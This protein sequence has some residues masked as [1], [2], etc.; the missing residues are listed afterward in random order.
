MT[1]IRIWESENTSREERILTVSEIL[2]F[3][4]IVFCELREERKYHEPKKITGTVE[5]MTIGL[6]E[7]P[8]DMTIKASC[9]G[10]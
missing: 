3:K 5:E 2:C 1:L 9:F 10:L 6:P 8:K 4:K 7:D